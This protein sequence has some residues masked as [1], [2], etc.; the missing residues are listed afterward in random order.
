M[1]CCHV[2][3]NIFQGTDVNGVTTAALLASAHLNSSLKNLE[4]KGITFVS[5]YLSADYLTLPC[6]IFLCTTLL[7]KFF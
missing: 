4:E 3:S 6:W 5:Q 1:Y 7:P 2:V